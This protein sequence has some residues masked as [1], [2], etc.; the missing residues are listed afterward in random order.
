MNLREYVFTSVFENFS[1]TSGSED[2]GAFRGFTYISCV[3]AAKA[4]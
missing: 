1:E 2:K 4:A 3:S